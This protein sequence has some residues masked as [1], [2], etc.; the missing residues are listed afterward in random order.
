MSEFFLDDLLEPVVFLLPDLTSLVFAFALSSSSCLY[1]ADLFALL[2]RRN[3]ST[4]SHS[5]ASP[6]IMSRSTDS[7]S[8]RRC[9]SLSFVALVFSTRLSVHPIY[10]AKSTD[11][12]WRSHD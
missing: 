6:L 1:L 10:R 4:G 3:P 9:E 7:M 11:M 2:S 8:L 12:R 5:S